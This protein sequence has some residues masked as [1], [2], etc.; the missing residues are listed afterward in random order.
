[1]Q[2]MSASAPCQVYLLLRPP[3]RRAR[4]PH[5][6]LGIPASLLVLVCVAFDLVERLIRTRLCLLIGSD[7]HAQGLGPC[8][9]L[10][11]SDRRALLLCRRQ[12]LHGLL[13]QLFCLWLS[14]RCRHFL[15]LGLALTNLARNALGQL[16]QRRLQVADL[17]YLCAG[18]RVSSGRQ[19]HGLGL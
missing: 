9:I 4:S 5:C 8:F 18:S 3:D 14:R 12:R 15:D 11:I 2:R 16:L 1:M 10:K 19:A 6:S 7:S 17:L 13:N